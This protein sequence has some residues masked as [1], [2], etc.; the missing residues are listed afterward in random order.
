MVGSH[1]SAL[2]LTTMKILFTPYSGGSIAHVI[3]S[4]AIADELKGRG[5]EILFTTTRVRKPFINQAGYEVFG[6][7]HAE[8]NLNDEKDQSISYFHKNRELF[9]NW[10]SDELA[11]AEEFQPDIVV[12]SPSFF[13]S[14]IRHK[15]GIP[16]VTI[17]NAQWLNHFRGLLGLGKSTE[18]LPHVLLRNALRPVFTKRFEE[19][20][21]TE[22]REF[23]RALNIGFVPTRR[24][25]L[26]AHNPILIPSVAE[27]EPLEPDTRDDVHFIGPLF[28]RGFEDMEFDRRGMFHDP[29]RPL[30]YVSLGGSIFKQDVYNNLINLF[31]GQSDWNIIMSIGPNFK[32][33]EFPADTRHFK[34]HEYVPGLKAAR[35]AELVVNTA[36]HGTVMQALWHGKPLVTIPHNIDQGTIAA[37]I[38]ELG[39]GVNLNAVNLLDFS[40]REKYFLKATQVKPKT[41]MAAIKRVL[42]DPRYSLNAKRVSGLLRKHNRAAAL[43]ADYIELYA[44]RPIA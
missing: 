5:H 27:F 38:H 9:L 28:W 23:Y 26:H 35:E 19:L 41:I 16:Y 31:I 36:S 3:R 39:V 17:L 14:L 15:Y 7:G 34:L 2:N 18:A 40:K 25:D 44:K 20:Y 12:N 8:V 6:D 21:L 22:I 4:L 11:A 13:G 29:N 37:R 33:S 24:A 32:R 30:I 42:D 43:G 1:L 10:L